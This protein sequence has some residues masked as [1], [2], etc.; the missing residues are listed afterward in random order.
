MSPSVV[1]S[2]LPHAVVID[3]QSP[4]TAIS[5]FS[6]HWVPLLRAVSVGHWRHMKLHLS[7]HL[8]SPIFTEEVEK[9]ALARAS[10]KAKL[11]KPIQRLREIMRSSLDSLLDAQ[12]QR[13]FDSCS[14]ES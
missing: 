11:S 12:P 5:A 13:K 1:A 10:M 8:V 7:N 6:F 2:L 4:R 14:L 3:R 9:F